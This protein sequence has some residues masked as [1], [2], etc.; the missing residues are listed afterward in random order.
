MRTLIPSSP[1]PDGLS[2]RS[3]KTKKMIKTP[4]RFPPKSPLFPDFQHPA[5]A[6]QAPPNPYPPLN[7]RPKTGQ[8][9]PKSRQQRPQSR[10]NCRE[11]GFIWSSFFKNPCKISL[12]LGSFGFGFSNCGAIHT[13]FNPNPSSGIIARFLICRG[14]AGVL[15]A[16]RHGTALLFPV[17][18]VVAC[19]LSHS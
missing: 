6:P 8:N 18:P 3:L 16:A 15:V 17:C 12:A 19:P 14:V 11:M 7:D 1:T 10:P 4:P 2:P 5:P 9:G 13:R